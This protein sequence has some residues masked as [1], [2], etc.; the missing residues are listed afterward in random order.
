MRSDGSLI[1]RSKFRQ[2]LSSLTVVEIEP[3]AG[4]VRIALEFEGADHV[5]VALEKKAHFG[6]ARTPNVQHVLSILLI[7]SVGKRQ[8]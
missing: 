6:C 4:L 1:P 3:S 2:L 7:S 5:R 8:V